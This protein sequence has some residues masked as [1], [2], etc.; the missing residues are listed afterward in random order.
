MYQKGIKLEIFNNFLYIT[1][2]EKYFNIKNLYSDLYKQFNSND[3][4]TVES[5][6]LTEKQIENLKESTEKVCLFLKNNK[7]YVGISYLHDNDILSN[8]P[9]YIDY[10]NAN[11]ID[12][13]NKELSEST[14][15]TFLNF[16]KSMWLIDFENIVNSKSN[17]ECSSLPYFPNKVKEIQKHFGENEISIEGVK[18]T[19][20]FGSLY[21]ILDIVDNIS[22]LSESIE[23]KDEEVMTIL[24]MFN[25]M[26]TYMQDLNNFFP[27]ENL[28]EHLL[29]PFFI[30]V[31]S[32]LKKAELDC[33]DLEDWERESL[34]LDLDSLYDFYQ[35]TVFDINLTD[36]CN[37]LKNEFSK[38]K[39][40]KMFRA[41]NVT[42]NIFYNFEKYIEY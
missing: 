26:L 33:L 2:S 3:L 18:D 37:Y 11:M 23:N 10:V 40:E 32:L 16:G 4:N 22:T 14:V 21:L 35:E 15:Q 1:Y 38:E 34:D 27:L 28:G 24:E 12:N 8:N 20:D 41:N 39:L 6:E 17:M 19:L 31:N 13:S 30:V 5:D 29:K 42:F 36:L 9:K 25:E 7:L